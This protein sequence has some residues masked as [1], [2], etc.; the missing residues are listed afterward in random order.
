MGAEYRQQLMEEMQ[1]L[2]A[3]K[4]KESDEFFWKNL[5][6]KREILDK[7]SHRINQDKIDELESDLRDYRQLAHEFNDLA[8]RAVN[9]THSFSDGA[10]QLRDMLDS[11]TLELNWYRNFVDWL[12]NAGMISP[13]EMYDFENFDTNGSTSNGLAVMLIPKS[14][15]A[16]CEFDDDIF[17]EEIPIF[18][19]IWDGSETVI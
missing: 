9:V 13:N 15:I 5:C 18:D 2:I 10:C 3:Q 11:C 16:E 8:H 19:E 14:E 12:L 17:D 4:E 7:Y 1:N 6:A